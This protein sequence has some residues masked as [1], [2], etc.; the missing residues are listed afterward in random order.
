MIV[1]PPE[2][3]QGPMYIDSCVVGDWFCVWITTSLPRLSF[4]I[5]KTN[6]NLER[7]DLD[8][9]D[10]SFNC[11]NIRHFFKRHGQNSRIKARLVPSLNISEAG[12][13]K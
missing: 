11:Y 3:R 12:L 4:A 9:G 2:V 13:L 5:A 6:N 8:E 1:I 10:I 7:A